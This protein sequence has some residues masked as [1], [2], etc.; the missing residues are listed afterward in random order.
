MMLPILEMKNHH[1]LSELRQ[2]RL[3]E[4]TEFLAC[5]KFGCLA[6]DFFPERSHHHPHLHKHF[7]TRPQFFTST[8]KSHPRRMMNT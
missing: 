1:I 7:K 5:T 4:V 3:A 6:G 8:Q 2:Y